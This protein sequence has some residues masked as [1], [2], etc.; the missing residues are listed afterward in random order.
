MTRPSAEEYRQHLSAWVLTCDKQGDNRQVEAVAAVWPYAL[1]RKRLVWTAEYAQRP[2]RFRPS[3]AHVDRRASDPL[4][5]PWPA[6]VFTCGRRTTMV[7][8]RIKQ[9]SSGVCKTVS[10]G[11]PRGKLVDF[12]LI[13]SFPPYRTP[14]LPNVLNLALPPI[15]LDPAVV[16]PEAQRW[17]ARVNGTPRPYTLLLLGG[18]AGS[19]GLDE[20]VGARLVIAAGCLADHRGTVF[21]VASRRTPIPSPQPSLTLCLPGRASMPGPGLGATTRI[22]V[23]SRWP[24][25]F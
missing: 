1:I 19:L 9:L 14:D 8:L 5:P 22:P 10:V 2:P 15:G 23:S 4:E 6:V 12:D 7:A 24:M 18:P 17:Q 3:F 21:V 25:M 20:N 13:V 16:E 11:R